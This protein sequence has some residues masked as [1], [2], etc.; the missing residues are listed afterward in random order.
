VTS[1]GP[2]W[3]IKKKTYVAR[4]GTISS[5]LISQKLPALRMTQTGIENFLRSFTFFR[6]NAKKK[7]KDT[8]KLSLPHQGSSSLGILSSRWWHH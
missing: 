5:K 6:V 8:F 7:R 2:I 1:N 4:G 3:E